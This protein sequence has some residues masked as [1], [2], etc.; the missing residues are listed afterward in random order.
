M[1]NL[2]NYDQV[3]SLGGRL[4]SDPRHVAL[5]FPA[6]GRVVLVDPGV[7]IP[8]SLTAAIVSRTMEALRVSHA[9]DQANADQDL[10]ASGK[11]NRLKSLESE[12]LKALA[13]FEKTASAIEDFATIS[14][15]AEEN[16]YMPEPVSNT[17]EALDGQEIRAYYRGLEG[18]SRTAALEQLQQAPDAR[19]L[20]GLIRSPIP[21]GE[22]LQQIVTSAWERHLA[23]SKAAKFEEVHAD[24]AV[25]A[26]ATNAVNQIRQIL[27]GL[28][29][30]D[31]DKAMQIRPATEARAA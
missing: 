29:Y 26:W 4:Q 8:E 3:E 22:P 14:K 28:E 18:A 6:G 2:F 31:A 24:R 12:R 16:L 10:S 11:A 1:K 20:L 30:H 21:L 13:K 7:A 25:A 5:A 17:P 15:L 19:H 27:D 23:A 9:V